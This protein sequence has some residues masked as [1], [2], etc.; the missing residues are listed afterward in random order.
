[1]N[2]K[3]L[4]HIYTGDGKGKT[5]AAIGLGVRACG[6]GMK[7]LLVQ[8]LKSMDTAELKSL[9]KLEPDFTVMRGFN[10]KKFAWQMT[11]EE[12]HNAAQEAADI[13]GSVKNTVLAGTYDLVIIDE[14]LGVISLNFL[15]SEAVLELINTK[16]ESLEL[17][18]TGRNAP[19]SIISAADYVSEI[20]AVKHP[21]EQGIPARKG[22]EF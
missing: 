15:E 21:F 19:D 20:K 13:F 12:L 10:C 4:V 9:K 22:I 16:P 5:T 3:G 17:V 6:S 18:I 8:F 2:K 1:M 11:Q 14:L 7:V